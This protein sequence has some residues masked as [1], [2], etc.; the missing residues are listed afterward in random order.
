MSIA[1]PNLFNW[2]FQ[3]FVEEVLESFGSLGVVV[4]AKFKA[5]VDHA[6]LN[7]VLVCIHKCVVLNIAHHKVLRDFEVRRLRFKPGHMSD[8][9][10]IESRYH[11]VVV[12]LKIG[13]RH[14]I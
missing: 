11:R 1:D 10:I 7:L 2:L 3:K 5:E 12:P 13:L 4:G 9:V 6:S 8:Q 14:K